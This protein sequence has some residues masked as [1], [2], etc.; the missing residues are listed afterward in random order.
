MIRKVCLIF[1]AVLYLLA[2]S[3]DVSAQSCVYKGYGDANCDGVLTSDDYVMWK[4]EYLKELNTITSDFSKDSKVSLI[5]LE[6]FI[7]YLLNGLPSLSSIPTGQPTSTGTVSITA[8]ANTP[9]IAVT[10][11]PVP[12]NAV[13]P[14]QVLKLTNWK[15]TLPT[16]PEEDPTEIYQPQLA[17]FKVDPWFV[18]ITDANGT[19]V[20]FRAPVNGVTTSGSGYPRSE[21]REM[22]SDGSN[23]IAWSS[24][25]GVH[26]MIVEEAFTAVPKIKKHVVGSQIHDGGDDVIVI[27]L[28]YPKLFIDINGADG[29][30]LDSNYT[31]GK[32]FTVKYVVSNGQTKIY[33]NNSATPAYTLDQNYSGAYFKAGAYT[34]SKCI[35]DDGVETDCSAN[36]YG[37]VVIYGLSVSHQ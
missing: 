28:E 24:T 30:T 26:T 34:Q 18:V 16:G 33:Y 10:A 37:E 32:K 27:R 19:G 1:L 12:G 21:L 17:T 14:A 25:S 23:E 8:T 22:L 13:Y 29:P 36:N 9:T 6:I 20:R 35:P 31:L 4:S 7:R 5:D 3:K 11:T 2:F 15:Q